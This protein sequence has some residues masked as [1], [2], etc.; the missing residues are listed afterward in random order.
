MASDAA[1]IGILGG[2]FD[3]VHNGHLALAK[4]VKEVLNLDLLLFIPAKMPPHK[5]SQSLASFEHRLAM[6]QLALAGLDGFSVSTLEAERPGPSYTFDTL[7]TLKR[8]L[9]ENSRIY[10]IIGIDACKDMPSWK[11]FGLLPDLADFV[12]V[13]RGEETFTLLEDLL[14]RFA[15]NYRFDPQQGAWC[16]PGGGGR[17]IPLRM[18][19]VAVSS[20]LVRDNLASGAV[21]NSLL[22]PAVYSYIVRQRL[23]LR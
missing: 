20:I 4:R 9:P 21:I 16:S 23:Y 7:T 18:Q 5:D 17:F 2:T 11:D 12:V 3:P 1:K 22:P 6:L 14:V 13:E 8:S 10:F 15:K 19:P